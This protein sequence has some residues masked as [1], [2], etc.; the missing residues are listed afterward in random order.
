MRIDT[1]ARELTVPAT[2]NRVDILEFVANT[3]GGAKAYESA[4]SVD[5]DAI[6]F[7]TALLLLGLDPTHARVPTQRFDEVPPAG[8]P[9]W[10]TVEWTGPSGLQRVPVER[11]LYDKRTSTTMEE[12]PWVYTGSA[13]VPGTTRYMAALDGVL[14]GFI[15][16]PS[17]IIENPRSGA[18][19]GYGAVIY[20]P[21]LGLPPE[22][23]VLLRVSAVPP[24]R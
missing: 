5:A 14:I 4:L 9:V 23:P 22:T 21:H 19:N 11:L 13:F 3:R 12:G 17:P 1:A 10:L 18:V 7:N 15:H 16:S 20:N 6:G 24:T 8:D 2:T